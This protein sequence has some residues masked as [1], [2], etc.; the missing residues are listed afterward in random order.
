[1]S[2]ASGPVTDPKLFPAAAMEDQEKLANGED[3]PIVLGPIP[4]S[5]PNP[6][7]DARR[8]LP[9]EDGTSAYEARE[10]VVD[11]Y[12]GTDYN[13]MSPAELKALAEERDLGEITGTGK[14]GAIKKADYVSALQA[15]D[16]KDMKA[17]D[18]KDRVAA[19]TTQD[20]LDA[21]AEL[22][23]NSD[24]DYSTVEDA[25]E[26][27]QEEINEANGTGNGNGQ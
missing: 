23:Q 26:K 19:A 2:P 27:K 9:L 21:V 13:S 18:F 17:S 14:N 11:K 25:I 4:F 3:E 8:M 20:E 7:T 24:S 6:S 12:D 22:Y 5:S 16:T 10:A 15:D 1:M